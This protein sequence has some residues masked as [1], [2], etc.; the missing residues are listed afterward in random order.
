MHGHFL[1]VFRLV[2]STCQ[3][4]AVPELGP[5]V[6]VCQVDG[7]RNHLIKSAHFDLVFQRH[8]LSLELC[9]VGVSFFL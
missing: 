1:E 3:I 9:Q 5:E 2:F 8:Y 4:V 6:L 7:A